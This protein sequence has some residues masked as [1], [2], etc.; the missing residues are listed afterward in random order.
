MTRVPH[1]PPRV[2]QAILN[3]L[4]NAIDAAA[5]RGR[6]VWLRVVEETERVCV[7]VDDDGPGV[8]SE[9]ASRVFEPFATTKPHGQ[10]TGLGLAITRQI[11]QDHGGSVG[12]SPREGGGT[13]AEIVLPS[14]NV[15]SY[16]VLV[17]D[18]DPAV[19]RALASE[20][21]REGFDVFLSGGLAT[22]RDLLNGKSL[23][24]LVSDVFEDDS[25]ETAILEEL[26]AGPARP[27]WLVVTADAASGKVDGPDLVLAKPWDRAELI[28]GVRRLCVA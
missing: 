4:S 2:A 16:R 1:D 18:A 11:L 6:H 28:D 20:L 23:N 12:L 19:R 17:I 27:R 21:R 8:A 26:M 22:G 14:L 7:Q 13:R 25:E 10:G 9:I 5:A 24:V 15:A 3:L